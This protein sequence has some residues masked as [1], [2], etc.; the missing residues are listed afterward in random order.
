MKKT[1]LTL[2]IASFLAAG[3]AEAGD[4]SRPAKG[5]APLAPPVAHGNCLSYDFID[6]DYTWD[7][8]GSNLF[9]NGTSYGVGFSKSLGSLLFVNFAFQDGTYDY[10]LFGHNI[11]VDT[12]RYRMGLGVRHEIA[13]CIDLTFEG[14]M[15][16]L[17]VENSH[18]YRDRDYD[19]WAYYFGPGIR[20]RAGRFEVYGKA[21]YTNREGDRR[22]EFVNHHAHRQYED[23]STGWVFTPGMIYHLTESIGLKVAGEFN[24]TD[25][26]LSVGMRYHF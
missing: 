5:L 13:R 1:V 18:H 26:A 12:H 22:N 23:Y 6:L 3:M 4:W 16:H 15:D 7:D 10:D 17:D 9:S 14:G 21:L 20:A 2:A 25:S 8:F 24:G 11:N 19:S